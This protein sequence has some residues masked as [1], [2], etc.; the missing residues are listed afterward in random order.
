MNRYFVDPQNRDLGIIKQQ[1]K[2]NVK[3]I[4]APFPDIQRG[5]DQFFFN[6]SLKAC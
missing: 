5:Y 3:L 6:D 2:P 1:R 4:I